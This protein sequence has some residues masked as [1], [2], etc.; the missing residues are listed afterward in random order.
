M[1]VLSLLLTFLPTALACGGFFCEL[2]LP[3]VQTGEAIVF[4]VEGNKVTMHVQILYQG[5]AEGFSWVL[6]VPFKPNV[7]VGLDRIFTA[8]FTQ[9]LPQFFLHSSFLS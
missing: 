4:G 3:V 2:A 6:P 1:K 8:M 7:A 9:T 5:P